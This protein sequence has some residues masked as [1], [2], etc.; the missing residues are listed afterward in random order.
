MKNFF[1]RYAD[2]IHKTA[3]CWLS[4]TPPE[5]RGFRCAGILMNDALTAFMGF[6]A[7]G[8]QGTKPCR[9]RPRRDLAEARSRG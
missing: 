5:Q 2:K 1:D 8:A 7:L 6:I 9:R 4:T 3:E